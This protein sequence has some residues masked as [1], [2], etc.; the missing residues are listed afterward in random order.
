MDTS[1]RGLH[2]QPARGTMDHNFVN[3]VG[4]LTDDPKL[5]TLSS[6]QPKAT[7]TVATNEPFVDE[8]TGEAREDSQFHLVVAF[9]KTATNITENFRKGNLIDLTGSVKTRRFEH[10]GE[11]QRITE[12]EAKRVNFDK[13]I[14]LLNG[15]V[16]KDPIVRPTSSDLV[17]NFDLAVGAGKP[18]RTEGPRPPA[19]FYRCVAFA[20]LARVVQDH[21]RK[22]THLALSGRGQTRRWTDTEGKD[23][24]AFEVI[25]DRLALIRP[26]SETVDQKGKSREASESPSPSLADATQGAE[27]NPLL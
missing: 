13:N 10:E 19:Q 1:S 18:L 20:N 9:G 15:N 16:A 11:R 24:F 17:A 22:G 4:R 8:S 23:R 7:C 14:V 25:V 12:I 3:I 21:V 26:P 6:G 5:I 27:M 2:E